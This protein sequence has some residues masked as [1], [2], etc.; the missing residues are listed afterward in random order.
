MKQVMA[1]KQD[2]LFE[3]RRLRPSVG[4]FTDGV[5]CGYRLGRREVVPKKLNS[6]LS[7]V[8][9]TFEC[10]EFRQ[11]ACVFLREFCVFQL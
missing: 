7:G 11:I 1:I 5:G 4:Q 10:P 2:D 9:V 8:P 3:H 6:R